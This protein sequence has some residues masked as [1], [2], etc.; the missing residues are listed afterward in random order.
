MAA[1]LSQSELAEI[2]RANRFAIAQLEAGHETR[3]IEVIF[4]ALS[5]LGLEL[6]VRPRGG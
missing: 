5:A 6:T 3:A 4:D 2:A 1:G